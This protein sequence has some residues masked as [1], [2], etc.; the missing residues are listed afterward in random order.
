MGLLNKKTLLATTTAILITGCTAQPEKQTTITD[1]QIKQEAKQAI[2]KVGGTLKNALGKKMKQ[3]GPTAAATFCSTN[4]ND[5]AKS[6]MKTLPE[7]TKVKRIT[8]K[9]RNINNQA[10]ETQL[11]VLNE[12]QELKSKNKMPKMLVKKIADDHYQVYKPL[13]VGKKCLTCHGSTEKRNSEAYN[14][15]SKKYPN[16]KAIDYKEG[17]LRGAFF[18]DIRK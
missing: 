8:N 7:G 1:A 6:A 5:L 11:E 2:M 10:N 9:A 15:I 3:G 16:D 14:I 17:D 18:V 12:L 4:A 13:V